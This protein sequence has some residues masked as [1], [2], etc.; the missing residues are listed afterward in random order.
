MRLPAGYTVSMPFSA[1]YFTT[2][3]TDTIYCKTPGYMGHCVAFLEMLQRASWD[4]W[5]LSFPW[6]QDFTYDIETTSI[7]MTVN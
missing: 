5:L 2:P 3:G 4:P 6:G 7:K 1:T